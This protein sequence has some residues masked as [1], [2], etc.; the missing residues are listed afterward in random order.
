MKTK[1]KIIDVFVKDKS[2]CNGLCNCG[3]STE[4]SI[5]RDFIYSYEYGGSLHSKKIKAKI[6]VIVEFLK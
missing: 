5:A 3:G 4:S 2:K 6:T 1:S